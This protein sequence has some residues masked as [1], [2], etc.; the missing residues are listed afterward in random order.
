MPLVTVLRPCGNGTSL[1]DQTTVGG[2][3][4]NARHDKEATEFPVTFVTLSGI[5]LN[6]GAT[7]GT[8]KQTRDK[9]IIRIFLHA[10]GFSEINF[11]A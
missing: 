8:N 4:P 10:C 2:G 3:K 1:L 6:C 7:G 11:A 5:L 9:H